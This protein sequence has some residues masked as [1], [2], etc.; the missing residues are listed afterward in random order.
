LK[1]INIAKK[2]KITINEFI[3]RRSTNL[4]G[5][6]PRLKSEERSY[7]IFN[8]KFRF[9]KLIWIQTSLMVQNTRV[10]DHQLAK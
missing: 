3:F 4:I 7:F 2:Y 8:L 1:N 10:L 9:V 6:Q 5:W